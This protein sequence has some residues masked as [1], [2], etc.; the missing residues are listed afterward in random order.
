MKVVRVDTFFLHDSIYL[1]DCLRVSVH[2]RNFTSLKVSCE[3]G[4]GLTHKYGVNSTGS[5]VT[6]VQKTK[7]LIFGY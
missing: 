5:K 4:H 7:V 3:V 6:K 1:S 2:L